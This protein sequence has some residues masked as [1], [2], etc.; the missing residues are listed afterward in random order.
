ME[1]GFNCSFAPLSC[2][3]SSNIQG[4]VLPWND[5]TTYQLPREKPMLRELQ[6]L[7][8]ERITY[9][10]KECVDS[11]YFHRSTFKGGKEESSQWNKALT[12]QRLHKMI[13]H[14]W[15]SLLISV[16]EVL[17]QHKT[18]CTSKAYFHSEK[19]ERWGNSC[20]K[21]IL[22]LSMERNPE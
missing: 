8:M 7:G 19:E 20:A 10:Q 9:C 22:T 2:L 1:T 6:N 4:L 14:E 3:L 17:H 12:T 18:D 13:I 11:A 16:Y 5:L 21:K 15:T